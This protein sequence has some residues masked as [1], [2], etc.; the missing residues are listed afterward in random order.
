M[1]VTRA[2]KFLKQYKKLRTK[3]QIKVEKVLNIFLKDPFNFKLHNHALKGGLLGLRSISAS[4]DLR[5]I[6]KIKRNYSEIYLLN[7]GTHNQVY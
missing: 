2:K 4:S 3:D 7:V 5:I 6:F 1:R